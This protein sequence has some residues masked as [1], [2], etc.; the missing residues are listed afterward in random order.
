MASGT[1]VRNAL[2]LGENKSV[3]KKKVVIVGKLEAYFS[4]AG[5]QNVEK[6]GLYWNVSAA[7]YATLYLGYKAEIPSTVNAYIVESTNS[8][9]AIMTKVEGVVAANTGLIL[10]GEGEHLFNITTVAATADVKGNLLKGTVVD[11]NIT[12]DAYVL[13]KVDGV[14]G[15]YKAK[16]NKHEGTAWLNN[17]NKAYLPAS[18]VA[19]K[20]AQFFGFDW[21]GTTGVENVEVENEV[22]AIYDLTGRR[23][24]TITAPGIYIVGGKKVLVK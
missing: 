7:G 11:E 23:V 15:L 8:T 12:E 2:N 13:G 18:A 5:M 6:A 20:S 17:A 9:H 10:E 22:K 14:V 21:G 16:K 19:N 24:E 4:V 1:A 3:Y